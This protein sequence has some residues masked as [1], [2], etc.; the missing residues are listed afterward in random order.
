M[1]EISREED[2]AGKKRTIN[3]GRGESLEGRGQG[4]GEELGRREW[5]SR[6]CPVIPTINLLP[7][8]LLQSLQRHLHAHP[9]K[10][11]SSTPS[12]VDLHRYPHLGFALESWHL[13]VAQVGNPAS[14]DGSVI[15]PGDTNK[16][17]QVEAFS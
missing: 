15:G 1:K 16:G 11:Q 12:R 10:S 6:T 17:H 9:H 8:T 2:E 3:E 4:T 5:E 7:L 13:L 14:V